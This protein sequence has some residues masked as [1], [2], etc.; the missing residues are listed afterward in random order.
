MPSTVIRSH[1]YDPGTRELT[2]QFVT[3]RRYVYFGV[4]PL[5]VEAFR[6]SGSLGRYFN[7]RIRD[8]YRFRELA[9]SDPA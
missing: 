3:G 9:R 4:P 1:H 6:T 5:E 8:H 7:R 2:L